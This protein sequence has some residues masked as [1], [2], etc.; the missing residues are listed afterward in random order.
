MKFSICL[1]FAAAA[2]LVSARN[3]VHV[4]MYETE[5]SLENDPSSPLFF[6]KE[7]SGLVDLPTTVYGGG[8]EYHGFGDKYQTLRSILEVIDPSKLVVVADARDV[9]INIPQDEAAANAVI[10]RFIDTYHRLTE[11]DPNAVVMSAEGQCCVSA[12]THAP[13]SGY[14]DQ[15][16]KKR[17]QRACSSGKPGCYWDQNENI[18]AWVDFH[19][20]R[21]YNKTGIERNGED[22]GDVYLNAGLMAGFPEDLLNLVNILD[23][24][25][26][27]DDQAV[28]SGLMYQFP[29]MIVLDYGQEMF[30]NNQ[31]PRG[32]EQG[33]VFEKESSASILSHRD[34]GAEPLII[35]TP[36]KF[37]G[38]LDILIEELGGSS[39]QRYLQ[40]S[41]NGNPRILRREGKSV[42]VEEESASP[43]PLALSRALQDVCECDCDSN[44]RQLFGRGF[45]PFLSN[46]FPSAEPEPK[47][48]VDDE[49]DPSSFFTIPVAATPEEDV[50][51]EAAGA[52]EEINYGNYGNYGVVDSNYGNYGTYGDRHL[53]AGGLFSWLYAFSPEKNPYKS[54]VADPRDYSR[55]VAPEAAVP[56]AAVPEV[57][58]IAQEVAE[59]EEDT[60]YGNYGGYGNYGVAETEVCADV[61]ASKCSESEDGNYGVRRRQK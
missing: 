55:L 7:R 3:D 35:H 36:G 29:D 20:E 9:V 49:K 39:Q 54:R 19:R 48:R 2:K 61:C 44:R 43:S 53:L 60:N 15:V 16:T 23:I 56:E 34:T 28:L 38:C 24:A 8:L 26:T 12:M 6:F 32:L 21:A 27:E 4:L 33:C 5:M 45:F 59:A 31:W 14:F 40:E 25:P 57:A 17:T 41:P 10:D 50:A 47:S 22:T 58:A 30:G 1:L 46:F 11:H 52:E 13:P 18:Y 37:Y 51:P 42:A